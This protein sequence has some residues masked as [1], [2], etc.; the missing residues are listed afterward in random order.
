MGK[1]GKGSKTGSGSGSGKGGGKGAK[2]G[3][4][5]Q[6]CWTSND[7]TIRTAEKQR[8]GDLTEKQEERIRRS[9]LLNRNTKEKRE[10][11]KIR[12]QTYSAS[13]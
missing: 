2:K 8:K 12:L 1:A 3:G 13:T 10:K 4:D 7:F 11:G 6:T 5:S 9:A